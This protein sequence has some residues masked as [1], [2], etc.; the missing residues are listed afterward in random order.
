MR[1]QTTVLTVAISQFAGKWCQILFAIRGLGQVGQFSQ[2]VQVLEFFTRTVDIKS[3]ERVP[4]SGKDFCGISFSTSVSA[5]VVKTVT[6]GRRHLLLSC[7]VLSTSISADVVKTLACGLSSCREAKVKSH[8]I[9]GTDLLLEE[10]TSFQVFLLSQL[11]CTDFRVIQCSY[12][13]Q[14]LIKFFILEERTNDLVVLTD[15]RVVLCLVLRQSLYQR[16]KANRQRP[17]AK[18][19]KP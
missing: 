6:F 8:V 15:V 14:E 11:T 19:H 1:S 16:P 10:P 3:F 12:S 13:Y 18:G 2:S 7:S 9:A 4:H 5:D 17:K